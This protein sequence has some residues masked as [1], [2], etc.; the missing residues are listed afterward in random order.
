MNILGLSFGSF[1]SY[2]GPVRVSLRTVFDLHVVQ[3]QASVS[4]LAVTLHIIT[5]E[6]LPA[7]RVLIVAD[8]SDVP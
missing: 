1:Y 8:D 2:C 6:D 3:N 7:P 4:S 5:D